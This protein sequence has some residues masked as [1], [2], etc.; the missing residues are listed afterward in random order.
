MYCPWNVFIKKSWFNFKKYLLNIFIQILRKIQHLNKFV[1]KF[2]CE[3]MKR[4]NSTIKHHWLIVEKKT[5]I[6]SIF[7]LLWYRSVIENKRKE[8]KHDAR[9]E[10]ILR[11]WHA[12]LIPIHNINSSSLN[13]SSSSIFFPTNTVKC[14]YD[15]KIKECLFVYLITCKTIML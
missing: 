3:W 14:S 4:S 13:S 12:L 11:A 5:F 10:S 2:S 15:K 8:K 1:K 9:L 6:H 7:L